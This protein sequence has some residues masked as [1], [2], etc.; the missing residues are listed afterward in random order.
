MGFEKLGECEETTV[1]LR[2]GRELHEEVNVA[3]CLRLAPEDRADKA[4]RA[5]PSARTSSVHPAK[6]S[7]ACS[8]LRTGDV[9]ATGYAYC[10]LR[11][12]GTT[13]R[14]NDVDS[15]AACQFRPWC[16][17]STT[18]TRRIRGDFSR[19]PGR[20]VIR[21][22]PRRRSRTPTPNGDFW[23]IRANAGGPVPAARGVGC[24]Q[25]LHS[26]GLLTLSA[27]PSREGKS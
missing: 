19:N 10:G 22:S 3:V 7:M 27:P 13:E 18:A 8:R 23:W 1:R 2:P 5:T 24:P 9:M 6:R 25:G 14:P 15:V 11:S 4:S 26:L 12:S 20:P 16:H 17:P 21:F